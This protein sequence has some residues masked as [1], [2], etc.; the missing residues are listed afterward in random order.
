MSDEFGNWNDLAALWLTQRQPVSSAEVERHARRQHL[1][2]LAL[3]SAEAATLA[4]AFVAAVWI[5]VHTAFVA[6]S[7]ISIVSFGVCG[8]LQHRM[9]REPP[10]AGGDDLL[11][12]LA[13][14]IEREQWILAQLGVG[15]AVTLVTLAALAL[16][17]SD[18]VRYVA[19]TPV[20]RLWALLAITS[21]VLAILGWNLW[22]TG[23]AK[24][25]RA[26]LADFARRLRGE[27]RR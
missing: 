3:A 2:M 13:M 1:H 5:A 23:R 7:A 10:P 27:S 11:A 15:R 18:H 16:L 19:S 14:S 9:R 21:F 4:L 17:D 8:Y 25:R 20:G 22:L 26:R 24:R 6:M 12:S